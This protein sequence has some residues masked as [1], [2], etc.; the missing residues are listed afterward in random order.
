MR[1]PELAIQF[2]DLDR[3]AHAARLGMWAFLA[4]EVLL[5]SGFFALYA[6]YRTLYPHDFVEAIRHNTLVHGSVNTVVL[7]TSSLT[8]ALGIY[9]IRMGRRRTSAWFVVT[10]LMLGFV[11]LVI[12]AFEYR[13]HF[14]HGIYPGSFYTYEAL[15]TMGAK[16]F[17]TLYY[18]MTATH[19]LHVVAGMLAL[20]WCW[21]ML[22]RR[23][24]DA[25]YHVGLEL[26]GIYWHLVDVVWIF[27]WPLLY[28]TR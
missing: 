4:S 6:A 13:E 24:W 3:Q 17:F 20:S 27:L 28:L 12:K 26:S 2:P 5:F 18:L 22:A 9:A 1:R 25:G 14:S 16:T 21:L 19:A 23:H 10:T 8:V 11:F 15:P 7:I